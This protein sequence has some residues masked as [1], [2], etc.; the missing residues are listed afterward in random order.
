MQ[1]TDSR[2]SLDWQD[3]AYPAG[4]ATYPVVMVNWADAAAYCAWAGKRL[5]MEAESGSA[6][7]VAM[8]ESGTV[9]PQA[10]C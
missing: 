6:V 2:I 8:A 4:Q 1:F 5:P 7:L 9:A 10:D 3:R